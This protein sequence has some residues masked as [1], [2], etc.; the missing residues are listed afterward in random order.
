MVN[1]NSSEN[2]L[3]CEGLNQTEIV[4]KLKNVYKHDAV[5]QSNVSR[6]LNIL[7]MIIHMK[8][9][10]ILRLHVN[11]WMITIAVVVNLQ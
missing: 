1:A 4:Q 3:N 2:F 5:D 10:A 8:M 6:G 7:G 11:F 9:T